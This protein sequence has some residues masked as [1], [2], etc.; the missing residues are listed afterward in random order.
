MTREY[1][2]K[3]LKDFNF[4]NKRALAR[5]DLNLPIEEGEVVNDFRLKAILPTI[6]YLIKERAAVIL[7]SHL[8]RPQCRDEKFS[9]KPVAERL[10]EALKKEVK[11]FDDYLNPAVKEKIKQFQPGQVALLENL[12]FY[13]EE[14]K[15]EPQFAEQLAD[16]ADIFVEDGFGVVHRAHASTVGIP[17]YLPHCAG[18]L[19]EKEIKILSRIVKNPQRPLVVLIGGAKISSKIKVVR[20]FLEKADNLLLGGALANTVISAKGFAIGRSI[21]E[22]EMVEEVKKLNLTDTKLHIPVDVI[23]SA[24]AE[25]K[26]PARIA[27]VGNTEEEEMILDIGP[28]TIDIFSN[29]ISQAKTVVWSGPMGLFEVDKFSAG[30]K[31]IAQ[32]VAK[33][34]AFKVIGGGDSI[35]LLGKLNFLDKIDHVSTG[36]GAM[37]NFLAGEKM[38]GIEA[39]E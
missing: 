34:R 8:G 17:K 24:S 7:I 6:D 13:P 10:A 36:G 23:V 9:M 33:S 20:S 39:L 29:I 15:N 25:G 3:S 22:E 38:P 21:C 18:L 32:I 28:D 35:N 2:M 19:L 14:E 11:F 30:S 37:L 27:P 5:V 12:R 4:K 26:A 31:E 16:L 1:F